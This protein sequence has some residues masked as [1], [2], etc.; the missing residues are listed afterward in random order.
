MENYL[1]VLLKGFLLGVAVAA[2]VGPITVLIFTRTLKTG[3][4]SGVFSA[5]GASLAD[6]FYAAV[7]AFGLTLVSDFLLGMQTPTRAIGA[8]ILFF[9][10]IQAF[11][12]KHIEAKSRETG[13]TLWRGFVVTFL[14][15]ISNPLT[16][17][18]FATL[19]AGLSLSEIQAAQSTGL[20]LVF[21]TFLGTFSWMLGI[22][23]MAHSLRTKVTEKL[24]V[25][26]N[27]VSG[28]LFF[29]FAL[30]LVFSIL[31]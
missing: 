2:P 13:K 22:S 27:K 1:P 15:T 6:A 23:T 31:L 16:I 9:L 18:L 24:L 14:L 5:A 11:R 21:G 10:G 8:T 20:Y 12:K 28:F 3:F 17:L 7:A 25:R 26:L 30:Y 29:G 4:L 19:F